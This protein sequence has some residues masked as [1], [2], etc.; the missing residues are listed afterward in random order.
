LKATVVK[1][2]KCFDKTNYENSRLLKINKLIK[3]LVVKA[4]EYSKENRGNPAQRIPLFLDTCSNS[5][6]Q[7][8]IAYNAIKLFYRLVVKKECPYILDK[9]KRRKRLPVVLNRNEVLSILSVIKNKKHY[10]M[11]ALM[12]AGGLRVS[13]IVSLKVKDIDISSLSIHIRDSKHHR[14]RLTIFS[15]IL[16]NDMK[17]LIENREPDEYLFLTMSKKKYEIRTLQQILINNLKKTTI[18]KRVTCHTLRH[19]FATHLMENGTNLK[20][21]QELLGHKSIKTTTVYL[22]LADPVRKRI[23]S[24]L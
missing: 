7:K 3:I 6:E 15:S 20:S 10:L 24:P 14:D 17:H 19:S 9:A 1:L 16:L 4:L 18:N 2:P 21:I 5:F 13:E 12:Y 8:R 11:I 23:K 22:H